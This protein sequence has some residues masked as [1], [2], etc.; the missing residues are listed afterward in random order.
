MHF[1]THI[2]QQFNADQIFGGG[3]TIDLINK[4]RK[5]KLRI[6][7]NRRLVFKGFNHQFKAY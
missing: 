7:P 4:P 1:I 5:P 3:N 6:T 2:L